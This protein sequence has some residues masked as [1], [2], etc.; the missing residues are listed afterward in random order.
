MAAVNSYPA[1]GVVDVDC[2]F[3]S[4]DGDILDGTIFCFVFNH[5][6]LFSSG[7]W[8]VVI[9]D[10]CFE[11]FEDSSGEGEF[12]LAGSSIVLKLHGLSTSRIFLFC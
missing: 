1:G 5:F 12:E 6:H 8:S 10:G 2:E 4:E 11:D 3:P 9:N 7:G